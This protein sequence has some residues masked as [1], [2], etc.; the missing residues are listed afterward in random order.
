M[1]N[2]LTE[3]DCK[4]FKAEMLSKDPNKQNLHLSTSSMMT[5]RFDEGTIKEDDVV[6]TTKACD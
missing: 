1:V 6:L 2:P 5:N 3:L 4:R